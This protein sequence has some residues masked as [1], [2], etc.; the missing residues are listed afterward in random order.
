MIASVMGGLLWLRWHKELDGL[1]YEFAECNLT[2]I[3]HF[4]GFPVE[5]IFKLDV[6]TLLRTLHGA[7]RCGLR[8][9]YGK[10]PQT[11]TF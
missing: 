8:G 6:R 1:R 11:S 5:R 7:F 3:S 2:R 9:S 10:G 4:L